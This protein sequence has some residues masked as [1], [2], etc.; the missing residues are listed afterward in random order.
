MKRSS[1]K[2]PTCSQAVRRIAQAPPQRPNT[3]DGASAESAGASQSR[4]YPF[5]LRSTTF[6]VELTRVVPPSSTRLHLLPSRPTSASPS[7]GTALT[8]PPESRMRAVVAPTRV[9]SGAPKGASSDSR[10]ASSAT[11]SLFSRTRASSVMPAAPAFTPAPK[12][13][14]SGKATT[15]KPASRSVAAD[16]SPEPLSTST[17]LSPSR[18]CAETERAA[19]R[20][21]SGRLQLT[22]TTRALTGPAPR[23]PGRAPSRTSPT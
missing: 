9:P 16:P 12:P 21:R 15:S 3:S 2:G 5:P 13:R 7:A 17:I 1:R 18:S 10:K 4:S 22:M 19:L 14:L 8:Q 23:R 11:A 6:P 20:V